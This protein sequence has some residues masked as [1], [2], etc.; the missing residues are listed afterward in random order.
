MSSGTVSH[1]DANGV[2]VETQL[3]DAQGLPRKT[4]LRTYP[5]KSSRVIIFDQETRTTKGVASANEIAEGD[6][7]VVLWRT[8][9]PM[10]M[11]IYR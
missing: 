6:H 9:T 11:F 3:V 2:L 4:A 7:I 1:V 10:A 5:F 8:I